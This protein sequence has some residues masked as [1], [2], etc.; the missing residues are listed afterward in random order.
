[1]QPKPGDEVLPVQ[2]SQKPLELSN[3]HVLAP[4]KALK[5]PEDSFDKI[6]TAQLQKNG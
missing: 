5:H 2:I 6:L 4:A 3:V 1:M